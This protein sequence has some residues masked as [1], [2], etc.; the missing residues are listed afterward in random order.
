MARK[1]VKKR[2]T[3]T[4]FYTALAAVGV[5]GVVWVAWQMFSGPRGNPATQAVEVAI[6]PAELSRVQGISIGSNDAPVVIY[7]FADFQCPGCATFAAFTSPLIKE[8]L[9]ETGMAR[10]VYYDFPISSIHPHSFLAARGAR[11]AN[12]QGKFWEY[13]DILYGRQSTWSGMRDATDFFVELAGVVGLDENSFE[14]C[15]RSDRFQDEVSRSLQLGVMLGVGSTP[16]IVVN[17]KR[18]EGVPE[19]SELEQIVRSEMG[20]APAADTFPATLADSTA[21]T[22]ASPTP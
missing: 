1:P 14:T 3:M 12:E 20:T 21:A 10:F 11:C 4:P 2:Q 5:I 22:A 13:H 8:R 18:L 19:F 17:M 6:D 7:E 9:V 15:L 16:T